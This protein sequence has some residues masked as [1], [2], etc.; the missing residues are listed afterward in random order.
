MELYDLR[1]DIQE[2]N[3]LSQ[4]HP[5]DA[6]KL[7]SELFNYLNKVN[8]RFPRRNIVDCQQIPEF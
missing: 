5:W 1:E 6:A 3:D 7:E 8:A 4:S 2:S